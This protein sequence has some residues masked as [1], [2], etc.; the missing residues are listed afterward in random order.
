VNY[1]NQVKQDKEL[2]QLNIVDYWVFRYFEV[3]YY[4]Y[5]YYHGIISTYEN[6]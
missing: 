6:T 2:Q 3:K 1:E 4:Y 5:Y